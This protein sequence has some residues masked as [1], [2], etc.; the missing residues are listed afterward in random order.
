YICK[1]NIIITD[2]EYVITT[3]MLAYIQGCEDFAT[4]PR[5]RRWTKRSVDIETSVSFRHGEL[6][7]ACREKHYV[8]FERIKL[9]L[10]ELDDSCLFCPCCQKRIPYIIYKTICRFH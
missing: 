10:L 9:R 4:R 7:L 6:Y 8:S 1:W 2:E 3:P 5:N